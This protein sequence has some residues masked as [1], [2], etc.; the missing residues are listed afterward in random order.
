[1]LTPT[2]ERPSARLGACC[3]LPW[4]LQLWA[5]LIWILVS[6]VFSLPQ[7]TKGWLLLLLQPSHPQEDKLGRS[8]LGSAE[9]QRVSG[10][11]PWPPSPRWVFFSA[12]PC[13]H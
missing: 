7:C 2:P 4:Q 10:W 13:P 3:R 12:L 9:K 8:L 1:M 11:S 5:F 6:L